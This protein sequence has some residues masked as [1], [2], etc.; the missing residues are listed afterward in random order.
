MTV[1][2]QK[3]L[4]EAGIASRRA[5]ERI[6]LAGQVTVNGKVVTELGT[7]VQPLH[8]QVAV[9]GKRVRSKKKLYVALHKP[10]GY[11]C[12]R[13]DPHGRRTVFDLLPPEWT[14]LYTVGRLDNLSE[15]LLFLTNDG[16][17]ALRIMHPRYQL[18]KTY[19][20]ITA[21]VVEPARLQQLRNGIM[22]EGQQLKPD[23]V[24]LVASTPQSSMLELELSEGKNREVRRLFTACG[25]EVAR[26]CRTRIGRIRLGELRVGKWRTLT[27]PEINSLLRSL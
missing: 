6:I 24:R 27:E 25:L 14:H 16:D 20:V 7:K 22:D 13:S 17:F 4:A 21:E 11:L 2:L 5:A 1:R 9:D 19:E 26:L 23:K 12:T 3:F 15:G 18:K 8:D 10:R